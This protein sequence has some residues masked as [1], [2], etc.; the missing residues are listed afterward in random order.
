MSAVLLL[1]AL[2]ALAGSL[3]L[4]ASGTLAPVAALHLAFGAAVLPLILTAL[5]EFA[6]V[7]TRTRPAAGALRYVPWLAWLAGVLAVA[8]LAGLWRHAHALSVAATLALIAGTITLGWL[9]YRA[10]AA[11]G[12]PHPCL[13]WYGAALALLLA[14]LAAV[15]LAGTVIPEHYAAARRL[16]LHLNSFGFVALTAV[17]TLQVLM[18]TVTGVDDAGTHRRLRSLFRYALAASI[19]I[20]LG[21]AGARG[22]A[23]VGAA[24][25]LMVLARLAAAWWARYRTPVFAWHGAAPSLAAALLGLVLVLVHG[26]LH[27]FGVSSTPT[28]SGLWLCAFLLPLVTGAASHLLPVWLRPQARDWHPHAQRA[29]QRYGGV[30]AVLFLIAGL[31]VWNGIVWGY[32]LAAAGLL[33][34]PLGYLAATRG[35]AGR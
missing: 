30:R 24:L 6:P 33:L 32:A 5:R 23:L 7:L 35:S 8:A 16:H 3:V 27:A 15:D 21:A 34:L 28:A 9:I 11:L 17:G 10:R 2:A 18:P 25:W 19:A 12:D 26:M 20:G 29:L 1:C 13:Y 14:A 31:L 22:L 4:L